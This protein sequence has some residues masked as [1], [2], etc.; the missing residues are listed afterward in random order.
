MSALE[1]YTTLSDLEVAGLLA[2]LEREEQSVSRRRTRLHERIDFVRTGGYASA[3]S[4]EDLLG[5]L[6]E[7]DREISTRRRDLHYRIDALR[8]ERSRRL[9]DH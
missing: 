3:E 1:D 6:L 8:A 2:Q 7:E 5:A 9:R 4:A